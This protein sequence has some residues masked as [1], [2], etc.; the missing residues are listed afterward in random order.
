VAKGLGLIL[1]VCAVVVLGYNLTRLAAV[2]DAPAAM[3]PVDML[4]STDNAVQK[5]GHEDILRLRAELVQ[6]LS[7]AIEDRAHGPQVLEGVQEMMST[8]GDL[9]DPA[10]VDVLVKH[11]GFPFVDYPEGVDSVLKGALWVDERAGRSLSDYL[12]A[13]RALVKIGPSC[14]V[15]VAKKLAKTQNQTEYDA[16]ERVLA[17]IVKLPND[18]MQS[19]LDWAY[20]NAVDAYRRKQLADTRRFLGL[21]PVPDGFKKPE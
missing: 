1:V 19:A 17:T 10:A 14:I 20:K 12:P 2:E 7:K 8:L 11:I 18:N 16:C 4:L 21:K 5:K 3:T 15:P 13:I 6:R 9:R